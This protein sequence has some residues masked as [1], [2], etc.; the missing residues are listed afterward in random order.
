MYA[1]WLMVFVIK[2]VILD[3]ILLRWLSMEAVAVI[4]GGTDI[5]EK[6]YLQIG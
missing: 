1:F 4:H 2:A 6:F 5:S 3:N